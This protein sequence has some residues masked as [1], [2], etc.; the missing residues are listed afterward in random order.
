MPM[1][2]FERAAIGQWP[3][4]ASLWACSLFVVILEILLSG[5]LS[6]LDKVL[7]GA[8]THRSDGTE[9]NCHEF[10]AQ[11]LIV[12]VWIE[13]LKHVFAGFKRAD[14]DVVHLHLHRLAPFLRNSDLFCIGSLFRHGSLLSRQCRVTLTCCAARGRRPFRDRAGAGCCATLKRAS[15]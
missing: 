14:D 9:C 4:W 2:Y 1:R 7:F 5:F 13:P 10:D 3:S 6:H 11:L 12:R 15:C 8:S